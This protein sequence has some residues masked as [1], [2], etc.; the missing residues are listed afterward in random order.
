M[1]KI[2]NYTLRNIPQYKYIDKKTKIHILKFENI[3]K[4][5]N[6]LMDEYGYNIKL[7]NFDN[8]GKKTLSVKNISNDNIKII[9][10]NYD[11]DFELFGYQKINQ[12]N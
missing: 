12:S 9:N 4:E 6:N 5:F 11:K 1:P 3:E 2:Q 10:K 8:V 7:K